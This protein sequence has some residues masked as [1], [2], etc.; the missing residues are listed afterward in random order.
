MK[1]GDVS[2]IAA[3]GLAAQ[4]ARLAVTATNLA[5][6]ETTRTARGGPYRRQDPVFEAQQLAAP[7]SDA[8]D[9]ALQPVEIS[10]VVEDERPPIQ[11]YQPGHPDANADGYVS[12]PH[13]EIVEE[14][15]NMIAAARSFQ[16]NLLTLA[17]V[18]EI[19]DAALRIGG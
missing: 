12:L 16:A 19:T 7:F 2:D 4:R 5:N 8:L 11:R 15:A 10:R 9:R 17:K 6:A 14:M 13:V 3:S 18:R 1:L